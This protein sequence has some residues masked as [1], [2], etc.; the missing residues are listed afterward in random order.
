MSFHDFLR[1]IEPHA[2]STDA[3]V[4]IRAGKGLKDFFPLLIGNSR[5]AVTNE[6]LNQV[7]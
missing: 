1:D 5:T 6:N 3:G 2:E 4:S 7:F